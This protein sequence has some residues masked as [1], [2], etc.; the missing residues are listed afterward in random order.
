M[1]ERATEL[2]ALSID[3]T[4]I[5]AKKQAHADKADEQENEE[6]I[7][8]VF[9]LTQID[10]ETRPAQPTLAQACRASRRS[11]YLCLVSQIL[12]ISL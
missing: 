8:P 5:A 10:G 7:P 3:E 2:G 9:G 4:L 6:Q 11:L 1:A 12:A